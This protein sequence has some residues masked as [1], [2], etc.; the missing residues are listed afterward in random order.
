MYGDADK[1]AVDV[2]WRI[3]SVVEG[4][5][6]RKTPK[7]IIQGLEYVAK[8]SKDGGFSSAAF[9]E[10]KLNEWRKKFPAL[11]K[12]SHQPI[13]VFADSKKDSLER[14][15]QDF[16]RLAADLLIESYKNKSGADLRALADAIERIHRK[17]R[18]VG[19]VDEYRLWLNTFL[20]KFTPP[21]APKIT[22]E[23]KALTFSQIRDAFDDFFPNNNIDE[24]TLRDMV[25]EEMGFRCLPEKRGPKGPRI[26]R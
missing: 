5:E 26:S 19:F 16:M 14:E 15:I 17:C 23:P 12:L 25:V 20:H 10:K 13:K 3:Y 2:A 6:E 18:S 24:K 4:I 11:L 8:E 22:N 9:D 7:S 1:L 21:P